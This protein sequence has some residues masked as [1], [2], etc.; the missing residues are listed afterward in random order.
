M[1]TAVAGMRPGV[2]APG[3]LKGP[4]LAEIHQGLGAGTFV[5]ACRFEERGRGD[6]TLADQP[7]A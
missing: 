7:V 1:L 3:G 2:P 4:S 5:L 6:V